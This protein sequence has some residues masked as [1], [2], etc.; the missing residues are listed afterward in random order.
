MKVSSVQSFSSQAPLGPGIRDMSNITQATSCLARICCSFKFQHPLAS[1]GE[2]RNSESVNK[3]VFLHFRFKLW[4]EEGPR[5]GT[6]RWVILSHDWRIQVAKCTHCTLDLRIANQ[7]H[8]VGKCHCRRM[9]PLSALRSQSKKAPGY[10]LESMQ[11]RKAVQKSDRFVPHECF[12]A[13][14]GSVSS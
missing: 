12:R 11:M 10:C 6:G 3:I 7:C 5:L 8:E 2:W 13:T 1:M 14:S 4:C 9:D